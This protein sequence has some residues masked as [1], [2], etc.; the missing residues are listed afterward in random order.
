MAGAAVGRAISNFG[1]RFFANPLA[2]EPVVA[3]IVGGVIV[4]NEGSCMESFGEAFF[5][6]A[7][8]GVDVVTVSGCRRRPAPPRRGLAGVA[9]VV[10]VG[11]GED[12]VSG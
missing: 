8:G 5:N 1:G 3:V 4:V 11:G 9:D 12:G 7:T 2:G 10:E 6:D